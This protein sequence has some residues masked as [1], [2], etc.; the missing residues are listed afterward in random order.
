MA[1]WDRLTDEATLKQT[2]WAWDGTDFHQRTFG[3]GVTAARHVAAG[4]RKEGVKPGDIVATVLTNG[5]DAVAGIPGIWFAGARIASLPI[6]ARGMSVGNYVD[7]LKRL[8]ALLEADCL[9]MEERYLD[10]LPL[11]DLG[12]RA[13]GFRKL[14]ETP[15]QAE[16]DPPPL[17]ETILI[18]FSSGTTGEPKGAELSGTAIERHTQL[19]AERLR[20]DPERDIGYMWIPLSHDMGLGCHL[21]AWYLG[22][23]GVRSW[24]E[25]FLQDPKTWLDDCAR[26]S[27]TV[28]AGPPFA[29]SM[30]ARAEERDPSEAPLSLRLCLVGAEH[31]EWSTLSHAVEVFG[32]RGFKL[33]TITAA[34]GLAEAVLA[35]TTGDVDSAPHYV[36][37][38]PD[39]VA[40]GE[41]LE[42]AHVPGHTRRVVSA[43]T[44][45]PDLKV[46]VDEA[47]S[48]I[49]VSGPTLASG[50]YRNPEATQARFRDGE[51]WTGDL[52]FIRDGELYVLERAD[53]VLIV[54]GR[55]IYVEEVEEELSQED[56]IRA[57]VCA[58]VATRH[59]GRPRFVFV[60][61]ADGSGADEREVAERL[62]KVAMEAAGVPLTEFVF[63][64][65]GM[66]PK[67]PS[68]KVQRYR[69]RALVHDPEVGRRVEL[70]LLA[71]GV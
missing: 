26:F 8:C 15:E 22:M 70:E 40:S 56:G 35:V 59:T 52:G 7:Q 16:I 39:H 12:V 17:D 49:V 10:L 5:E 30:A 42:T 20:L 47:T 23:S 31:V 44:P 62:R 53:D 37:I 4:L 66:F 51:F 71:H 25:R 1:L 63:L 18:Q 65:R 34:Y 13:I 11:D 43:G 36:D 64:E 24:P 41:V 54:G 28:T 61:E 32:P 58:I 69:V 48:E 68:G 29:L 60:G 46:R 67:T 2:T 57:G 21:L 14:V 3:E 33:E 27:V 45:L 55:N 38:T 50:Y 6:I 19:L 9:L